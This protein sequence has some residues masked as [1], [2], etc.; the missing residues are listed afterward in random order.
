M[1]AA[2][3][4]MNGIVIVRYEMRKRQVFCQQLYT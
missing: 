4:E 1:A 3:G 2:D